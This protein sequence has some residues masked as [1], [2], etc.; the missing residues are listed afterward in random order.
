MPPT[1]RASDRGWVKMVGWAA[2]LILAGSL[3]YTF[4]RALTDGPAG[5]DPWFFGAQ[6]LASTLFLVYSLRLKNRIFIAANAVAVANA[7]GTL[8]VALT[9]RGG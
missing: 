2:C 7:L 9:G 5:I 3:T 1:R 4:I 6:T 8:A